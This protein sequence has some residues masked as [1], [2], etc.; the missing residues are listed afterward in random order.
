MT[1]FYQ[2]YYEDSQKSDLF[3]FSKPFFNPELTVFFENAVIYRLVLPC[4][5]EKVGVCSPALKW[6]INHG[7]P[8]K[9]PFTEDVI[10]RD[11]DILSL[12]RRQNPLKGPESH[13]MLAKMDNWHS[14][15]RDTLNMILSSIGQETFENRREPKSPIYQNAF[16]AKTEIYKEFLQKAMIPAMK[17]MEDDADIRKRCWEDSG[18]YKLKTDPSYARM[19]KSKTGW[20]YVPC[21]TFILERLF[22]CWIH[23]KNFNI[24]YV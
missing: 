18:Y 3:P 16:I 4:K 9:E 8:M 24:Q 14:G 5:A 11:Y 12:S 20:D 6:K 19:I 15:T 13:F 23:G 2:I 1:D 21:H 10:N 22:S 17:V 7:I